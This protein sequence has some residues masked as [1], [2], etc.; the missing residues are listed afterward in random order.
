MTTIPILTKVHLDKFKQNL[1]PIVE[2]ILNSTVKVSVSDKNDL[3]AALSKNKNAKGIYIWYTTSNPTTFINNWKK[4]KELYQEYET[5]NKASKQPILTN[6]NKPIKFLL[7]NVNPNWERNDNFKMNRRRNIPLYI[8]KAE[9]ET[10]LSRLCSHCNG[11]IQT[12]ALKLFGSKIEK[13]RKNLLIEEFI[14]KEQDILNSLLM[15]NTH[16]RFIIIDDT[17]KDRLLTYERLLREVL[18]PLIGER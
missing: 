8:G 9:N 10:L 1:Q 3:I 6:S 12:S 16:C 4:R 13:T 18:E 17:Q 11:S 15:E 14:M 2:E 7:P 5:K